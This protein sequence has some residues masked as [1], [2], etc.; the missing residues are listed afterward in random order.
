MRCSLFVID[1]EKCSLCATSGCSSM[2]SR[3]LLLAQ[4]D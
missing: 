1:T 3:A 4:M 2:R